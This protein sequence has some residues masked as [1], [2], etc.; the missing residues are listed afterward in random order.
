[1]SEV[2]EMRP[3]AGWHI[4]VIWL[5]TVVAVYLANYHSPVADDVIR[6]S[7]FASAIGASLWPTLLAWVASRFKK[8]NP[9]IWAWGV[10][11]AVTAL[12]II[13]LSAA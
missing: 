6:S 2:S 4:L 3:S 10:G 7:H 1:M 5:V 8:G 13:A 11:L 12:T 9:V